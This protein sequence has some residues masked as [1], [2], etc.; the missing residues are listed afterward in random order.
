[1]LV[2]DGS[3]N[4]GTLEWAGDTAAIELVIGHPAGHSTTPAGKGDRRVVCHVGPAVA[5]QDAGVRRPRPAT[6][7]G[8]SLALRGHR[9]ANVVRHL[10]KG[11]TMMGT[12]TSDAGSVSATPTVLPDTF[13][14]LMPH[15]GIELRE[16]YAEIG[17]VRLHYVE[18]GDGPLVV[19]LHGFPEFWY[20]WRLQI[21]A[22]RG[23]GIPRRR[24][25]HARLQPV[26]ASRTASRPT[27][28]TSW[29]PTSAASSTNAAP[30]PRCWSATT[31]AEP[32]PGPP[33]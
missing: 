4:S 31:G 12:N 7:P 3:R 23:G 11:D 25:R 20:G 8:S 16:G 10:R 5:R 17:D 2:R 9:S 29:P 14:R 18:A 6:T 30:S 15:D 33:R 1:M 19:L 28:S 13:T 21:E 24:T 27:T 32:S 22:A 26:V